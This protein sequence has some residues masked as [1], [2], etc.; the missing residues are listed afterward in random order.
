MDFSILKV[1]EK[2]LIMATSLITEKGGFT[3]RE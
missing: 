1:G 2:K 3:V